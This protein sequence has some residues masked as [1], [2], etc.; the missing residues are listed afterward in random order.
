M[1]VGVVLMV[2]MVARTF[3]MAR[4]FALAGLLRVPVT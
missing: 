3:A 1:S 4:T 2:V